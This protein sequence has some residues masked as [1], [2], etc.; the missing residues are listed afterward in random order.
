MSTGEPH[1]LPID[2]A[3]LM[4]SVAGP[5]HGG[6]AMLVH[7]CEADG[8]GGGNHD[9]AALDAAFADA[10]TRFG[11]RA[12][13]AWSDAPQTGAITYAVAAS[14]AHRAEA[15]AACRLVVAALTA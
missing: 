7:H 6:T 14:A 10:A 11:A 4:A 5:A 12:A 9:A 2:L 15:F 1:D 3:A 13:A 8:N